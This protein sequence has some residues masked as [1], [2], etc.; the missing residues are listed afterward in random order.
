[1]SLKTVLVLL[2][3]VVAVAVAA[4]RAYT[5]EA[6]RMRRALKGAPKRTI[7]EV[8]D[9]EIAKIAGVVRAAT[10]LL[11]APLSGRSCVF[12]EVLVEEYRS[13][14]RSGHW[15]S[16]VRESSAVDFLVVDDTGTALVETAR[17]KVLPVHDTELSSGFL[18]DATPELQAFL[19]RHGESSE[20]LIFNRRLRYREGVF[21]PGERVRVLGRARWE[22]APGTG[23]PG[24]G[25][26]DVPK[27]LVLCAPSQSDLVASDD[28][29]VD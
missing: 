7:A 6:A 19:A 25:Y 24:V 12:Y 27:R 8:F 21:E 11:A 14:G 2:V 1:M 16:I 18:H 9:G 23:E 13:S 4:Y 15:E 20:G 5:S 28:P 22:L 10:P 17:M 29:R 26:R 3:L